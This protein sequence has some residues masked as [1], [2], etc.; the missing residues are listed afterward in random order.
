MPGSETATFDQMLP[1]TTFDRL[2]NLLIETVHSIGGEVGVISEREVSVLANQKERFTVV[3]SASFS[4]LLLGKVVQTQ[5]FYQTQLTFE[6]SAIAAFLQQL[7]NQVIG[8]LESASLIE[9]TIACQILQVNNATIQS[10][11]TLQLLNA[12]ALDLNAAPRP[13]ILA[14]QPVEDAVLQHIEQERLL[15][16]VTTQIRQSLEL[17]VI[18]ETT[19][20]QVQR[21]LQVDRL[22]IYQLAGTHSPP[23][24][25]TPHRAALLD[26]E[27]QYYHGRITYEALASKAIPS[28]L[29]FEE[30]DCFVQFRACRERYRKGF[31]LGVEDIEKGYTPSSCLLDRLRRA[32]VRAKL[33]TP[34]I[35]QEE[36]WG[37]LIAHQCSQPRQWQDNEKQ[38]LQHIAEHL[39]IG[40]YQ[41]QLSAQLQQQKQTLEERVI[42]RTQEIHDLL[43][44]TQ[45]LNRTKSDFLA[46]M[47]HELRTP[48][49][50]V[51]GMSATLLRWPF[52]PLNEKQRSY[53][54]IIHDSGEHL[55]AL[56]NDI[57]DLSQVEAGKAILNI[58]EFSLSQLARQSLQI[59]RD[60]AQSS[61]IELKAN[62]QIPSHRDRFTADQRRVKQILFNLLANAVKF[63]PPGG[64]VI[65]RIWV[66]A[67]SAIF[68]VEDTG[69]GISASQQPLLFQKFQQ[70]DTSYKRC[71]EGTGL[72]LA[73]T[74]QLVELHHGWI[75]VNSVEGKGSTFTVELPA[76]YLTS[77]ST[78]NLR[79]EVSTSPQ[80]ASARRIVL[81]EDHEETA[82]LVC[83]ILTAA[84]YQVIWMIDGSTA[85]AKIE[86]LQPIAVI[87]DVQLPGIDGYEILH[88]LRKNSV[89]Q[90]LRILVLTAKAMGEDLHRYFAAGADAYLTKPFHPEHLLY[91]ITA[92]LAVPSEE[93]K[94]KEI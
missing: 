62:L 86:F 15:N 19:V 58:S 53:L 78:T 42:Q 87:T 85:V 71:Y 73:L 13:A 80:Q 31:V 33:V 23:S 57:L 92:M 83:D 3:T 37:L 54:N 6:P 50:C 77:E 8:Y 66:E 81:I 48:L 17:R 16:Q 72:G 4:A 88:Q 36:L 79:R 12:L 43:L 45:S 60:K 94:V 90:H 21:F 67:N 51:I 1:I 65:L 34:I 64:K 2:G 41:A 91:K 82:T 14:S 70:L 40:I 75:E 28:V 46:T 7:Q 47:S 5:D 49:T 9:W 27:L 74:K 29:N 35:V 18:L 30:D 38:F 24:E 84:G 76:Q 52:G 89:T 32:E 20:E 63:T 69:I 10:Q 93:P 44:T 59:L 11:F 22:V 55:L 56:I 68:Q 26:P 25:Q 39:E 61:G